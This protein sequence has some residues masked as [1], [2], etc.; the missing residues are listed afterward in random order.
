MM[1]ET[2]FGEPARWKSL[3]EPQARCHHNLIYNTPAA[4]TVFADSTPSMADIRLL[5]ACKNFPAGVPNA[6]F[7]SV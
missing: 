3:R 5:L 7:R 1:G 2:Q 4:Y 6:Y